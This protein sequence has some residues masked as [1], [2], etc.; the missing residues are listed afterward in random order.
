MSETT[1]QILLD[2]FGLAPVEAIRFLR[3]KGMAI[4]WDWHD[5]WREEHAKAF[6]V[7]KV[8]NADLLQDI[9][10]AV[11]KSIA[12]GITFQQFKKEL[13][14]KLKAANWWGNYEMPD[15][16]T[17]ETKIIQLGSVDRLKTI[18]EQN[19]QTAYQAGHYARLTEVTDTLPY[20][21]YVS[22]LDGKTTARC[23]GLNGLV[24]AHDDPVWDTIYPPNH[25]KCRA[26]VRALSRGQMRDDT[27]SVTSAD[28]ITHEVK[29]GTGDVAHTVTVKGIKFAGTEYFPD[30][31]F[32]YNPGKESWNPDL[33]KYAPD[34]RAQLAK[35]G[36]K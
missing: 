24:F 22:V 9:R 32:D 35:S 15:A 12:D 16:N 14:P 8:L 21:Q 28:E 6:T 10:D 23:R 3:A 31:G 25:W 20:W 33:S 27:L 30:A 4:S 13:T 17:G 34:I 18:Y 1:P 5:V 29:V 7:A 11:D 2:A 19:M 26:I 36:I